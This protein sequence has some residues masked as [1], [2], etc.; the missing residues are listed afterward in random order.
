MHNYF[1]FLTLQSASP[2][3]E[4]FSREKDISLDILVKPAYVQMY[5]SHSFP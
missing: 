2:H 4:M 1:R 3:F 5:L